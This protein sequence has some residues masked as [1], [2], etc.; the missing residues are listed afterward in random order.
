MS[1]DVVLLGRSY[2]RLVAVPLG[3]EPNQAVWASFSLPTSRYPTRGARA[4]FYRQL[5]E[6]ARALPGVESAALGPIPGLQLGDRPL[7]KDGA[8][9]PL[10]NAGVFL[11]G[12]DY[13]RS[14]GMRLLRGRAFDDREAWAGAP[15]ALVNESA[16][17]LLWPGEDPVGKVWVNG[18][19]PPRQVVG[20]VADTRSSF[21]RPGRPAAYVPLDPASFRA[22]PSLLIR[23]PGT[24]RAVQGAIRA[25]VARLDPGLPVGVRPLAYFFDWDLAP[26]RFQLRVLGAF[27]TLG[28]L[29]AAAGIFGVVGYEVSRRTREIGIRIALGA[30]PR[31]IR[32][33]VIGQAL[34]P[35]AAGCAIGL[36][37]A[38]YTARALGGVLFELTPRDPISLG[39]TA[40]ILV[41]VAGAASYLPA[42]RASLVDPLIALRC[43]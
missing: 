6:Q 43:E 26:A 20:V 25:E 39:L 36:A 15:V 23:A 38:P 13:F 33:S 11:V 10:R 3:F 7:V 42:R 9:L 4:L 35:V 28:L 22:P 8:P 2:A 16:A 19:E 12:S 30:D 18:A 37:V 40:L 41:A 31:S 32:A 5:L 27:G 17:R 21:R 29:L 34:G 1:Q 24:L 14:I